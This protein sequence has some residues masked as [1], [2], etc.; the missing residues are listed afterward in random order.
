[1]STPSP[2]SG[3]TPAPRPGPHAD[4]AAGLNGHRPGPGAHGAARA[5]VPA[6]VWPAG[7]VGLLAMNMSIVG[8]TVYLATGDPSVAVEP[9]YYAKAVRWDETAR[10]QQRN[11][12]LG[13]TAS[14]DAGP[15]GR[16]GARVVVRFAGRD[17][18]GLSGLTV[19]G[20]A[21]PNVRSS[22]RQPL[23]FTAQDDGAYAAPLRGAR[24]GLW[25][26]RLRAEAGGETFTQTTQLLVP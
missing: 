20:V 25:Q 8:V 7:I 12:E 23:A 10:Q 5:R 19:A 4:G 15:D 1:M 22:D 14:A 16:G 11:R 3:P 9:D 24:P 21:F 13:W 2:V 17:G 26:L 18:A 6:W